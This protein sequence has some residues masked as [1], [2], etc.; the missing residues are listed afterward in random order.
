MAR[1]F[2]TGAD[3]NNKSVSNVASPSAS[4]DAVNKQYVDNLVAGLSYKDE[5]RVATTANGTLAS[6]FANAQTIDGVA[7]VTGDRIL[8]KD[9]TTQT[10]N[11]IYTVNPSGAPTRATDADTT[12]ELNNATVYVADGTVNA[13]RE[14]T[15]TTKNPVIGTNNIVWAQKTTGTAYTADGQGIEVSGSQFA[16]ELDGS[17]LSKSATGVKV[18][19][20]FVTAMA[21]A[22]LTEASQVLAV[23]AGTGIT[24]AADSVAV[25][26]SVV[27][28]KFAAN[29]VVTTN[30]Q[31]FTHGLG[32]ADLA[33][34]V[35]R[36]S[37]NVVVDCD[38]TIT[39]TQITID[40][41]AAPSAAEYRVIA[42]G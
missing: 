12:A 40:W 34:T 18:A 32:S 25:D 14:Y 21:G 15:Q 22:G 17:S 30:P 31:S 4:T 20:A 38:I 6:A 28:R 8:L 3:M 19:N 24:V 16:L 5:V 33:V 26:T 37:D 13:G 29:C 23:G 41:G 9:Q 7:L 27:A 11:G 2:Q 10:E 36:V 35:K 42:V 1:K 39:S